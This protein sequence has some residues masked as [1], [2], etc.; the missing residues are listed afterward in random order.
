AGN[1]GLTGA[2]ENL[3]G[4]DQR[5]SQGNLL[6]QFDFNS[7]GLGASWAMQ[8]FPGISGG[9]GAELLQQAFLEAYPEEFSYTAGVQWRLPATTL[10]LAARRLGTEQAVF[11]PS[12]SWYFPA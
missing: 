5:D 12:A 7:I 1:L 6:G 10:G 11:Q 3:P 2:W 8:V 9:I 4:L